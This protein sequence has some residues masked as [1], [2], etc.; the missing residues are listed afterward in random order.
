MTAHRRLG[1][2]RLHGSAARSPPSCR[3]PDSPR[4]TADGP[5]DAAATSRNGAHSCE[6][7]GPAPPALPNAP[8]GTASDYA[9]RSTGRVSSASRSLAVA[10]RTV[11]GPEAQARL[12]HLQDPVRDGHRPCHPRPVQPPAGR[13]PRP[14][15]PAEDRRSG[16]AT[17]AHQQLARAPHPRPSEPPA[18]P[19]G[20]PRR[21]PGLFRLKIASR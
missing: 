1:Y 2:P 13:D 6:L 21:H 10:S 17:W 19:S 12:D 18:S 9:R 14:H 7:A 16:T 20:L 8:R 11:T 5:A 4:L 15:Q 3:S